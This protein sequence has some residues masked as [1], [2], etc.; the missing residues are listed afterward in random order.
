MKTTKKCPKCG[1]AANAGF[2]ECPRCGVIVG[3]FMSQ[4]R[5]D[6]ENESAY[7]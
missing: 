7:G 1:F 5:Q 3:K 2:G 4:K 6:K